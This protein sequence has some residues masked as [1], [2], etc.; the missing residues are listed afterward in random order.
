MIK[1]RTILL[2]D[3]LYLILTIISLLYSFVMMNYFPYT[4]KYKMTDTTVE[5]YIHNFKIDGNKLNILLKGKERIIINYYFETEEE[6]NSFPFELGDNIKIYGEM[7][8]PKESSVF[9]L[10]D[11]K[12]HLYRN[13]IFYLFKADK[14]ELI[15]KNTR[16]RYSIK[17]KMIKHID[18]IGKSTSYVKA[19]VIGND[20]EFK[21]SIADSYQF[22]GVSHLFAISGSHITFLSI[23]ILWFLKRIR[24][25]ENKRYYIVIFILIF[26]MFLT[27]YAGSVMRSVVFFSLLSLNKMYYFHIKTI[28][29]LQ[30][31]LFVLLIFKPSLLY[32]VGFQFSFLISLY[33]VKYQPFISSIKNY[34]KQTFIISLIAFLVSIPI[35]INNFFQINLLS[36]IIN[37]LF[38]PYVSFILFPLSFL[39]LLFPFLDNLIFLFVIVLENI[40][41]Y[42]STLKIGE[43]ILA[44][45][46][47]IIILIYYFLISVGINKMAVKKYF[48]LIPLVILIFI[49]NNINYFS[50]YP[51][52]VF[53]DVGQGD[54]IFISLPHNKGNVLIDTGGK[55]S[56]E[57]PW[58][59]KNNTYKI[60]KDTI[61]PFLKSIG[62]KKLDYLILTHGDA[63]HMGEA[64]NIVKNYNVEQVVF[65]S[66]SL[67]KLEKELIVELDKLNI[68]YDFLKRGDVISIGEVE[69]HCLNPSRDINENDNSIVLYLKIFK[70]TILLTGDI[71]S[72]IEEDIILAYP[73]LKVDILKVGHHGSKTSTS[74]KFINT[75]KP[76]YAIIPVGRNNR[77]NH[78]SEIVINRLRSNDVKI[79]QTST[80]GSI[81][82]IIGLNEVT[83]KTA[84][85]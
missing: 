38:V 72:N 6:K 52:L 66:G 56:F 54:S 9:N 39:C 10:F 11:Y 57:Q 84:S 61:I 1:L 18:N 35:C 43:I 32:D 14:I 51:Y 59:Q 67:V 47:F 22:N 34:I 77:F 62:I 85:T 37:V 17:Q 53:I 75:I 46:P 76:K 50:R 3:P 24:V 58:Q 15:S 25:E 71:S 68:N 29:I 82:I 36:P 74:E 44:K 81:K 48:Y 83:I 80:N 65:N 30:L 45:P 42:L 31:T 55:I 70:H 23:I 19:L 27:D 69:M 26:Y 5:G 13:K 2:Y 33:L 64:L 28:N 21:E 16:L 79:L 60:G 63:D 20:D 40:S 78:P 41:L 7:E 8:K 73:K 49:H 4:S 12:K